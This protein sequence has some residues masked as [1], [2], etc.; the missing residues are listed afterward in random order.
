MRRI[1]PTP[2]L[3][4]SIG[5]FLYGLFMNM[6]GD[7]GEEG[8]GSLVA[9][10]LCGAGI[11][12]LVVF[13]ILRLTLKSRIWT[14][15]LIEVVIIAGLAFYFY[16]KSGKYEFLLPHNYRGYVVVVYGVD[17]ASKLKKPFFRNK[18][19]LYVP[20]SGI[21]LTS[22]KPSDNY[23]DPAIFLDSTLGEI[24]NLPAPFTRYEIPYSSDTL[25]CGEKNYLMDV[26]LIKDKPSW[27]NEDDI[28]N[29]FDLKL[30][31]A[32]NLISN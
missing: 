23:D 10:I 27:T 22:G 30:A 25:H 16:K 11:A 32:C 17:H 21:I 19:K 24:Q 7:S 12:G 8:W 13:S 29:R 31:E 2:L 9:M 6:F 4:I 1:I 15:V 5:L 20:S 18:I 14:Q 28:Q 3:I 26:W